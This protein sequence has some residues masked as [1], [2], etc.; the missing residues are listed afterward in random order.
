MAIQ[1]RYLVIAVLTF[2][3]LFCHFHFLLPGIILLPFHVSFTHISSHQVVQLLEEP[4][5]CELGPGQ[6]LLK[7]LGFM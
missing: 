2:C 4:I 6:V 7:D 5:R 1:P 3:S